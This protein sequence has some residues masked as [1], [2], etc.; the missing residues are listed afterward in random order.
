M[1]EEPTVS[2]E[3][4]VAGTSVEPVARA[5]GVGVGGTVELVVTADRPGELHVHASPEQV[6]SFGEGRST[7]ELAV[8]R[9]GRVD[10][11]E[12][13]TGTLVLR[14]LVQ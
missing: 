8:D 4:T 10:V 9:P 13:S 11:E 2:V 12:H 7:V 3:V 1:E 5:V 14:L 6:L